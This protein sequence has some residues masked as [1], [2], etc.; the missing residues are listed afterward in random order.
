MQAP[1]RYKTA[2]HNINNNLTSYK[3]LIIPITEQIIV[4]KIWRCYIQQDSMMAN[5]RTYQR[6]PQN[7]LSS[8]SLGGL[9]RVAT[10]KT[11]VSL[12]LHNQYITIHD[13]MVQDVARLAL[14]E[15]IYYGP[16]R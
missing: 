7:T 16:D 9:S 13:S 10:L 11:S 3:R 6:W 1:K 8:L 15:E 4:Q 2:D 5:F 12:S 14:L